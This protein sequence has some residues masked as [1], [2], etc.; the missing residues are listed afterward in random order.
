MT[1]AWMS[2][3]MAVLLQKLSD[4]VVRVSV[5]FL[6][7]VCNCASTVTLVQ[8]LCLL[9]FTVVYVLVIKYITRKKAIYL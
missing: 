3:E 6:V 7:P 1:L 8:S 9:R 2:L 4:K 5:T